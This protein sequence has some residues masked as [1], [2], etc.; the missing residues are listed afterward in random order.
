[1]ADI[2]LCDIVLLWSPDDSSLWIETF[3]NIQC[4]VIQIAEALYCAVC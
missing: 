4:D 2:V 3:R 1:M